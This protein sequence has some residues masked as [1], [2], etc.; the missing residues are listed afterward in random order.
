MSLDVKDSKKRTIISINDNGRIV[1]GRYTDLTAKE[2]NY[3]AEIYNELTGED[4]GIINCFLNY[5][6]KGLGENLFCS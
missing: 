3:I 5:D 4:I 1:I 6:G 2:K